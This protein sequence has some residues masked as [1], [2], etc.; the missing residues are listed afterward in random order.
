ME[1]MVIFI[2]AHEGDLIKIT[3]K[4]FEKYIK[5]AYEAGY[6]DGIKAL[7]TAPKQPI[8]REPVVVPYVG[9]SPNWWDKIVYCDTKENK[10]E[11]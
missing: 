2:D 10:N 7:S 5:Q 1:P 4:E 11:F 6:T 9:D 8:I 3:A